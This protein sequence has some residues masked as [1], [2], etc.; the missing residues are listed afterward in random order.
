MESPNLV[1]SLAWLIFTSEFGVTNPCS[2]YSLRHSR[3]VSSIKRAL[4]P[5][6]VNLTFMTV[7]LTELTDL[8]CLRGNTSRLARDYRTLCHNSQHT[9]GLA[10]SVCDVQ[11]TSLIRPLYQTKLIIPRTLDPITP[12]L[13]SAAHSIYPAASLLFSLRFFPLSLWECLFHDCPITLF[14]LNRA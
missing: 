5:T 4:Q 3:R 12:N 10:L 11:I 1:Q 6:C 7:A 8:L 14:N 13:V 2:L 9:F